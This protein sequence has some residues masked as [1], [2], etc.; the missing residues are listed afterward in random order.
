MFIDVVPLELSPRASALQS[1]TKALA[2]STT[3]AFWLWRLK[4][5]T[6]DTHV[7]FDPNKYGW[8]WVPGPVSWVIPTAVAVTALERSRPLMCF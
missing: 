4:F 8:G 3:P 7:R 6:I 1:A 5:R 2:H